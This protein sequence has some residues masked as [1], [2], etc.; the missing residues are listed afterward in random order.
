MK[1]LIVFLAVLALILSVFSISAIAA[2]KKIEGDKIERGV[3]NV[4]L[5]WTDVP[6]SIV[7]VTKDTNNPLLGITV[8]LIKGVVNAIARTAS[9]AVDV[10]TFPINSGSKK[11]I[12]NTEM[13]STESASA[14]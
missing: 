11:P 13:I 12:I 7:K 4:A 5:G 8:G 2:P 1:K 10:V 14:K 9:G 6:N 3:K